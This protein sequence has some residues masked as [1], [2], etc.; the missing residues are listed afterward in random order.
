MIDSP[1]FA[2][3]E[4]YII[5][6]TNG[7]N[8]NVGRPS[9][10]YAVTL[11]T[12]KK[13]AMTVDSDKGDEVRNYFLQCEKELV[14]SQ[15]EIPQTFSEALRLLA[16]SED[17]KQVL[18]LE[19]ATQSTKI[20]EDAPKVEIYNDLVATD[21]LISMSVACK[22]LDV[23]LRN[24]YG[25]LRDSKIISSKRGSSYNIPYQSYIDRGYF[26]VKTKPYK[27]PHTGKEGVDFTAYVTGS[28]MI[29]LEKYLNKNY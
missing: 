15:F 24:M 14:Q 26:V 10:D 20:K 23:G 9:T 5:M 21:E 8:S 6:S 22:A 4:D 12:A 19:V 3:G 16:D 7:H 11:D 17:E 18:A 2:E 27:N 29:W 25:F 28:G 1:Y 13:L